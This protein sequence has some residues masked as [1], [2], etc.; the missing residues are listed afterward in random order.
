MSNNDYVPLTGLERVVREG[1]AGV[2]GEDEIIAE[3]MRSRVFVPSATQCT[4]AGDNLTPLIVQGRRYEGPMIVVFDDTRH[5]APEAA[6]MAPYCLEMDATWLVQATAPD[7]G[8]VLF[9]GP[10]TGCEISAGQI[11]EQRRL[12]T[13]S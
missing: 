5:I 12:L 1:M 3:L 6:R 9:I 10:A 8:I 13:A 2:G 4:P 11:A 7:H